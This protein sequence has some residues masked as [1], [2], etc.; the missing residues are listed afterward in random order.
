MEIKELTAVLVVAMVGCI[1]VAG[2]IPVV[3]ES[4]S[5]TGT[6]TNDGARMSPLGTDTITITYA[7]DNWKIN[8]RDLGFGSFPITQG[9]I[10]VY[11]Q[12]RA[13]VAGL[14]YF[15]ENDTY[16][17]NNVN[18]G[19]EYTLE[20]IGETKTVNISAVVNG[21]TYTS[22]HNYIEEIYYNDPSG[23]F[24]WFGEKPTPAYIPDNW[25]RFNAW[26]YETQHFY[27]I[28]GDV[29]TVDG[30]DVTDS[31]TPTLTTSD[32]SGYIGVKNIISY[33][34]DL[35]DDNIIPCRGYIL[36]YQIT[37]EKVTHADDNTASIISMIPFIL[38]M[39]IVIMFIGV[40]LVRRYV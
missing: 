24:V 35:G 28:I 26:S 21:T 29:I 13:G 14:L 27:A 8:E 6:F 10:M 17:R 40:V 25:N 5:A 30:S 16:T 7:N 15:S 33:T 34:L 12:E 23:A 36:P 32:I 1:L 20:Y 11:G 3:G 4:V 9:T 38:I 31:V 39:G 18:R 2:F 19:G 37:A 22:T